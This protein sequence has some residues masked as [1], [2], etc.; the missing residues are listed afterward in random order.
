MNVNQEVIINAPYHA[1][2]GM[3]AKVVKTELLAGKPINTVKVAGRYARS[4][5]RR[6]IT[7][8]F[9]DHELTPVAGEGTCCR[10]GRD[11]PGVPESLPYGVLCDGCDSMLGA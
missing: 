4:S 1:A 11:L 10:C 5:V 9:D 3:R 6:T 2:H 7:P 8:V